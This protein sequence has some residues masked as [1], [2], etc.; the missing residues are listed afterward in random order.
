M[1]RQMILTGGYVIYNNLKL[2][3]IYILSLFL[4]N[5]SIVSP[6]PNSKLN[7]KI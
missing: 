4:L 3:L 7:S 5:F 6:H 2:Q 1:D